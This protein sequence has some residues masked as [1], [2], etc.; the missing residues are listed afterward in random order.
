MDTRPQC[1]PQVAA[2]IVVISPLKNTAGIVK[3]RFKNG[4][5][6]S[7]PRINNRSP[8]NIAAITSWQ[9]TGI[10]ISIVEWPQCRFETHQ[11]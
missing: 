5:M 3:A 8:L 10:T 11:C 2:K 6:N 7:N 4:G 1:Q 9:L